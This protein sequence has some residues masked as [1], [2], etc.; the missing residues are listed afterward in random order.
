MAAQYRNVNTAGSQ[1][2]ASLAGKRPMLMASSCVVYPPSVVNGEGK[3]VPLSETATTIAMH[4]YAESKLWAEKAWPGVA[5]RFFNVYGPGQE[6]SGYAG[7]IDKFI[8]QIKAG[9]PVTIC[10]TGN[11]T[12]DYVYVDDAVEAMVRLIDKPKG[13]YN[14]GTGI[15]TSVKSLAEK[16]AK[17]MG[18]ELNVQPERA[19]PGDAQDSWADTSKLEATCGWKP[20]VTLEQGLEWTIRGRS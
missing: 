2:V 6:R 19:R 15:P 16:I 3:P 9:E 13:P 18:V 10:G 12:R 8:K 4:P 1:M 20:S 17:V 7:V 11:Q 14:V 5:C